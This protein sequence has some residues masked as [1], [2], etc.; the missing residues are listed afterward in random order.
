MGGSRAILLWLLPSLLESSV[1]K[2]LGV[3]APALARDQFQEPLWTIRC[4]K[5]HWMLIRCWKFQWTLIRCW[6]CRFKLLSLGTT[7]KH[8]RRKERGCY[9]LLSETLQTFRCALLGVRM[10]RQGAVVHVDFL[11]PGGK[12][13]L[14][15]CRASSSWRWVP[16]LSFL[17]YRQHSSALGGLVLSCWCVSHC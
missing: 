5:F 6:K 10:K 15:I 8:R 2:A 13:R 16:T 7:D 9:G 17:C 3:F 14:W 4:W 12:L 11:T 1:R